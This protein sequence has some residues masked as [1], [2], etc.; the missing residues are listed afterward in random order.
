MKRPT[1]WNCALLATSALCIIASPCLQAQVAPAPSTEEDD[2]LIV[3]S[4]FVVDATEDA[5]SYQAK[6]TLAGTRVRT[7]L[8]D[9]AS[10]ISVVTKQFLQDTGARNTA[11]LLVYTT[12]TEVSG[13][14]G[15]FSGTGGGLTYNQDMQLL[16][17]SN[18]TRVRGLDS[19]DNTRDYF[20]TDIPWDGFNV[21]RV[22][23][24]R[25]PNSILFGIGSPAGIINTSINGAGFKNRN[26]VENRVGSFGSLRFSADF[27]YVVIPNEL[28]IRVA[29][30]DDETK[31]RQKPAYNHD[32]RVFGALRYTPKFFAEGSNTS[33]RANFEAGKVNANRPRTLPPVDTISPWFYTGTDG[34]GNLNLNKFTY[35]MATTDPQAAPFNNANR[36]AYP[37]AWLFNSAIGRQ[38]W[39]DTVAYYGNN[40][41]ST[42]T[43]FRQTS[44]GSGRWGLNSAGV[45]QVNAAGKPQGDIQNLPNARARTVT[46][47]S[48]Y[49]TASGLPGGSYYADIGLSDPTIFDFYNNLIDGNNKHEWQKW[50]SSNVA[51]A[52]TFFHDR[53]GFEAV[54]D[55][56]RYQD[57]QRIFLGNSDTYKIGVDIVTHFSNGDAN[58]NV[59]R[60]FVA[61]SD[62]QNNRMDAIDRDGL[63]FTLYGELRA[64]DFFAKESRLSKI[65]GRHVFT[66]LIS[67]DTKRTFTRRWATSAAD[68]AFTQFTGESDN[69][70]AHFRSFNFVNYISGDLR[71]RT[72]AS[73]A[74]L[75]RVRNIVK[76]PSNALVRVFD[77]HWAKPL[78]PSD[79]AYVNPAAAYVYSALNAGLW[80]GPVVNGVTSTQSENPA[81]YGG[82]KDIN[83]EYLNADE[84]DIDAL[85]YSSG[86]NREIISSRAVTWQ[87]YMFN[88]SVVPV[89]GWRRDKLVTSSGAGVQNNLGV[90]TTDYNIDETTRR[91]TYG[92]NKS[93][94]AMVHVPAKWTSALP[95]NT[96]FSA[97]FNRSANNRVSL[98]PDVWGNQIP[99]P[100][101]QTKEYG[102]VLNTLDDKLTLKVTKYETTVAN[103][104]LGG[105]NPLGGNSY[106][107]WAVPVWGTAM[108][109]RD[110]Q[111][112]K[113]NSDSVGSNWAATDDP[114]APQRRL[115]D[116]SLNPAWVAHPSTQTQIAAINAWRQLPVNQQ[117][118]NAYGNEVGVMNYAAIQAGNW[119][120]ADP[121]WNSKI[122][123][124]PASGG[125]VGFGGSGPVFTVDTL[126]KGYEFELTARPTRNWNVTLN[127][128]KTFATR[129]NLAPTMVAQ[130]EAMT[131]F[132]A[133]PAGDYRWWGGGVNNAIRTQWTNNIL[134]PYQ[135]FKSQE[136]LNA[137]EIAPWRFNGVT[138]YNF[139]S[140][141]LKGT[142]VGG[143]YRWEQARILGYQFDQSLNNGLGALDVSKPWK[144]EA[145]SHFDLW[146]GHSRKLT[147][148]INWR[149]QL[150][151]RNVGESKSLVPVV[152]NPNG[153]IAYSRIQEGMVWQLTNTLEF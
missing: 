52:Q 61:N 69:L 14:G 30:L 64:D 84:G 83:V 91:V 113:G 138:T 36:G 3:L 105:G 148:K 112:I 124:Q 88:E 106:Y 144:G 7:D 132:F 118:F 44:N 67:E 139:D 27:N 17:P 59:G 95:A 85:T 75:D 53:V 92:E 145:D 135:T 74:G 151:L 78:N 122:D 65:L 142:F 140:G 93:W 82:W 128:S 45:V 130:I 58:P 21:D 43:G 131:A 23:L 18:A 100:K 10:S 20:L 70:G 126:S 109:A 143:A 149:I 119:T 110:D 129:T 16:R 11:D 32:Q 54:Y 9:I 34:N 29:L 134:N 40:D 108:V 6:S 102:V 98:R 86:R 107:L 71:S 87:G 28:A 38:F 35:S 19:A 114:A 50:R 39:L 46:V 51:L 96:T 94:G 26:V 141:R 123:N 25:G 125:L 79:P 24:Q 136:G 49:Y 31:Y 153:E 62:E 2:D 137:P 111:F 103:A 89:F 121:L 68:P 48:S 4:P 55:Y 66:G 13:L 147:D 80:N 60:A 56:Q 22:D 97:F 104:S 15:N 73:G 133:G 42:P 63:R 76:A 1:A 99:N 81:N 77:N 41:S 57:G 101:G 127:A 72:T 120:A 150:N 47:A 146:I 116:G 117:F 90:V 5:N 37:Y 115:P 12:N 152:R 8:K 33:F